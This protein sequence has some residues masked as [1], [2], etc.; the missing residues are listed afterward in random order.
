[1][2]KK[3]QKTL[4][5]LYLVSKSD[6][7]T[8]SYAILCKETDSLSFLIIE[9]IPNLLLRAPVRLLWAKSLLR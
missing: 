1:M 7:L 6:F 8:Y 2:Q 9:R 5:I 4:K 3:L